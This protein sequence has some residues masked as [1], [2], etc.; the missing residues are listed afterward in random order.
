ME[1]KKYLIWNLSQD[2]CNL[3]RPFVVLKLSRVAVSTGKPTY[4]IIKQFR[5]EKQAH[6]YINSLSSDISENLVI[7]NNTD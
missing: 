4:K 7:D 5:T 2:N 1:I 3:L 6:D